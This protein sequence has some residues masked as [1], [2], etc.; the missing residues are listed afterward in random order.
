MRFPS[1]I[2]LPRAKRFDF[3]PRFYD[4]I[5]EEIAERTERIRREMGG[6]QNA[7][8]YTPGKITFQRKT[9]SLPASSL[10]QMAIAALLGLFTV[11]WLFYGNQIFYIL[12]LAVPVYLYFRFVKP[13]A[14]G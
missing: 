1:F 11:G 4:P 6:E 14:R 10:L 13:R 9:S 2:R 12:W 7:N 8:S 3:E 5:R